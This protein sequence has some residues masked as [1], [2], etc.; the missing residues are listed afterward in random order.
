MCL[1]INVL[2]HSKWRAR[3]C[4][5]SSRLTCYGADVCACVRRQVCEESAQE[6]DG[7]MNALDEKDIAL[8]D[9]DAQIY[10]LQLALHGLGEKATRLE[11]Y[12]ASP[13]PPPPLLL[14][15]SLAKLP[16]CSRLSHKVMSRLEA[17]YSRAVYEA[18]GLV[19]QVQ[20]LEVCPCRVPCTCVRTCWICMI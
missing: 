14:A 10:S 16:V 6:V 15:C 5:L 19:E 11:R 12:R 7:I 1:G 8:A 20:A 4:V 18:L 9:K 13:P 3:M 2:A 17:T